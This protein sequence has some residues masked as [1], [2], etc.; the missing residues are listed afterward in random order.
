MEEI[1][2]KVNRVIFA[3]AALC[4]FLPF[5]NFSCADV[6]VIEVSGFDLVFGSTLGADGL[7]E[8]AKL[9]QTNQGEPD[10]SL[11][12]GAAS[13]ERKIEPSV[14]AIVA[15]AACLVGLFLSLGDLSRFRSGRAL[16]AV[17]AAGALIFLRIS[18]SSEVGS[19]MAAIIKVETALGLWLVFAC[20][21]IA[22]WLNL[23][24]DGHRG[25]FVRIQS[26]P[27]IINSNVA[28]KSETPR[29]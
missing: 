17:V 14:P 5:I 10:N 19:E 8:M 20:L 22:I 1:K 21:A 12:P 13:M 29:S 25:A 26:E 2:P 7:V 23:T 9:A 3:L 15:F 24:S 27:R 28:Q 16:L 6:K 18:V 4:F 11:P